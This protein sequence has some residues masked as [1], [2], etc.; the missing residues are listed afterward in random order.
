[1]EL[2]AVSFCDNPVSIEIQVDSD[3]THWWARQQSNRQPTSQMR[4]TIAAS[5]ARL[6]RSIWSLR[7]KGVNGSVASQNMIATYGRIVRRATNQR[8]DQASQSP[9]R[10]LDW[11]R[12][13]NSV[14]CH[15]VYS[16][17]DQR[18]HKIP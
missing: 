4:G 1:M 6:S 2:A 12:H 3:G 18:A 17:V 14:E 16:L 15:L 8:C 10:Y 7:W 11:P 13:G 5:I 9:K